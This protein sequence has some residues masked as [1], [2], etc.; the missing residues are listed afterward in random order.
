[1]ETLEKPK[2]PRA[3][4]RPKAPV[5]PSPAGVFNNEFCI[6]LLYEKLTVEK[7]HS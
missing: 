5:S 6:V 3:G 1:M 7:T 4:K 2:E